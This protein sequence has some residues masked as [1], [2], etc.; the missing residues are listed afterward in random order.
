MVLTE[1]CYIRVF[2]FVVAYEGVK[3]AFHLFNRTVLQPD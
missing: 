3:G 1:W 2:S